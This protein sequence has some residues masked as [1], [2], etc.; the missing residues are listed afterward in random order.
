MENV[1]SMLLRHKTCNSACAK[2]LSIPV[3]NHVSCKSLNKFHVCL[4]SYVCAVGDEDVWLTQGHVAHSK[5]SFST[6]DGDD[7][8]DDSD[9]DDDDDIWRRRILID[10]R[11]SGPFKKVLRWEMRFQVK[12]F[13]LCSILKSPT[14]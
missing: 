1:N 4:L 14:S 11:P 5:R 12:C 8:G 7:D 3:K 9:D 6:H 2:L 10:T 13:D